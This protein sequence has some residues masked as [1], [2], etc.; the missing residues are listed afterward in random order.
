MSDFT[1][2]QSPFL[3]N[4]DLYGSGTA[5]AVRGL[6]LAGRF[7]GQGDFGLALAAAMLAAEIVQQA[8]FVLVGEGIADSLDG[9]TRGLQLLHQQCWRD[10]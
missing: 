8:R 6:D 9:H 5:A 1:L 2:D 7:A 3:A 10:L 4:F